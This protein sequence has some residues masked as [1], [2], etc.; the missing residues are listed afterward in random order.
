[1]GQAPTHGTATV[2]GL[3]VVYTPAHDYFG[4]DTLTY[5]ASGPGGTSAPATVTITVAG[6]NV[7][8]AAAQSASVLGGKSV[9][10]HAANGATN[11]PFTALT[12]V[13]PPATGSVAIQGTDA[14][15]T[16][17]ADASGAITFDFTLS[18]AFGASAP[19]RA[20]VEVNPVPVA[21]SLTATALAGTTVQVDLTAGARGGP[22]NAANVLTIEPANAGSATVQATATGYSLS[23]AAAATFSGSARI[24]Y[25]LTNAY[26]TSAPGSVTVAVTPRSDP[27]KDAEVVGILSAQ[28]DATRRM[29]TGQIGNFQRRLEMLH[30]GGLSGFSN[31]I[32]FA[33][34]GSQRGKD[35]YAA[36]RD[37][38]E[39]WN[40]RYLVQPDADTSP[41]ATGRLNEGGSLPGDVAVWTGGAVNFGKSQAGT[42]GNGTDF[43][44]SGL[45][46]GVDKQFSPNF[47]MG[48]GVGY[49]HDNSDIGEHGSR[50]SVDSYNVAL[51][52]SYRP[53]ESFYTDALIGY[54]WL[55]FDARRYVTDTGGRV[56]GSR[57]GKQMFG[58]FSTGYLYRVDDTQLTPYGRLDIARAHLDR[59]TE[60]GDDIYSLSYQRQTVKTSTVTLGLLAQWTAKRDYGVW[61]PQLRAEFGHDMQGSSQAAM[62]YADLLDGPLYRATLAQQSREHTLL[63]AGIAL[64]T[65]R[66]WL[67]RAEYQLQLDNSSRDNQSILIGIEKKFDP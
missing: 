34:A 42:S 62:R 22:F 13:G 8:V 5:T 6:G 55:S 18:N 16:A 60:H 51:Y 49:G 31:G 33:S 61:A 9:T 41:Q 30:S 23:F 47:A 20:T 67:L 37:Q 12:I 24:G 1:M 58:S 66:G 46:F 57:D 65:L 64:Q 19:A 7:P 25:T 2:S 44:T 48:A 45:S 15:Y 29:A 28:A 14:I 36:L 27:S 26:A 35:P 50:S 11:G 54:Q 43:T 3:D 39:D 56:H 52:A 38:R 17:A 32:S 4:T 21:P 63:G 59:Y 10:I 53:A 40:R